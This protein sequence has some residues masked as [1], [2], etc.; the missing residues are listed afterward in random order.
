MYPDQ[1]KDSLY[2]VKR[3][4][5]VQRYL[6]RISEQVEEK[7]RLCN[8]KVLTEELVCALAC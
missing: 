4:L 6:K 3:A 1:V 8:Q 5:I 7:K 2:Q